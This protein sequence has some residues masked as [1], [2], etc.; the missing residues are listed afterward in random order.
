MAR[1]PDDVIDQVRQ[2]ADIVEVVG[3]RVM[4]RQAGRTFKGVCPFHGDKDP[5]LVV[6]RER[7]TWHCFGCGE[8]GNVFGFVMK[9]QGLSFPEAVR[10]LAQ[11]LG[12]IIPEPDMDESARRASDEKEKLLRVL[13]V[14]GKFFVEQLHG[15]AGAEARRYLREKR[16]L[17]RR[18]IDEFG[19]GYALDS[20]DGLRR[21]LLGRGVSEDLALRAG[22]LA[23][24]ESGGSYDRFR[25]RV[26]FPIRDDR[27]RVVSFGGRVLGQGEPKYLNGP[28]SPLF[29]KSGAL[30]NFDRA[31]Q[32]MHRKGRAVVV[33]GYFD[34]ITMAA[35]GFEETVAPMGTALTAQQARLLA[36]AAPRV[37]L[38][39]DGDEAGRKAARR[40][41]DVFLGEGVH[42][43]VHLLPGGEDPDS[44][45]R[46]QG[47]GPLDEALERARPLAEA[48][49]EQIVRAGDAKSPEGKSAIVAQAGELIKAMGDP[50]AAWGY[51][52]DLARRL[53]LP[54]RVVAASLG[55]PVPGGPPSRPAPARCAPAP[56]GQ[57]DERAIL[58]M[59]LCS[60]EA[61]RHLVGCGI[62]ESLRD[63]LLAK[64]GR[65][66]ANVLD[67]TGSP[68]PAAVIQQLEDPRLQAMVS[69][70][71]SRG[72]CLD[73][74]DAGRQAQL[75]A[76]GL[77]RRRL[78]QERA[79][80]AQA[81]A[82][83]ERAG[84]A[85]RVDHLLA[86]RQRLVD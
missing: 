70:L 11:G 71:A 48:T 47:A 61:A 41:L 20:W 62:L 14:A 21:H 45:L 67:R 79:L 43:L 35:F 46:A 32:H 7:G 75:M 6:N 51:L 74:V 80:L 64:I 66:V 83:A 55:L 29:F 38:V 9:D 31:R 42:P 17:D 52:E 33:E 36:R 10:E 72:L 3:R 2:M 4:L 50:V 19:L 37:I 28:E 69:G 27:G 39:F 56:E 54:P 12:I 30:Y 81:I 24:R 73:G 68:D 78:R 82:E 16:G 44:F 65:A 25:G 84:D 8:G 76:Q 34:V 57:R 18:T 86:Q 49:I 5:S 13:E 26:V 60:A 59:A 23:P 22:L 53:A 40:S 77:R 58:E 63:P 85:Q 1:I 15:P